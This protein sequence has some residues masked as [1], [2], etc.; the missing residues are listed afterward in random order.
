MISKYLSD[1][2]IKEE[3]LPWHWYHDEQKW[4]EQREVYGFDVRDT[5]CLGYTLILLI[6]PRLKMYKEYADKYIDTGFHKFDYKGE[7]LTQQECIDKILEGLEYYLTSTLCLKDDEEEECIE[8]AIESL[9]LLSVI[10]PVL[11]W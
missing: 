2:G 7:T 4:V 1:L 10:F 3:N 5:W 8:K 6:Y 9:E 11:W